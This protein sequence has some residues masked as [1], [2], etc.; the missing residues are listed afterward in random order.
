VTGAE[1]FRLSLPIFSRDW[2]L[3]MV[4]PA[5]PSDPAVLHLLESYEWP[6]NIRELKNA[7]EHA[8]VFA[9]DSLLL[10]ENF[11]RFSAFPRSRTVRQARCGRLRTLSTTRSWRHSKPRI[12]KIG[13][14]AE[15]LG[16]TRK[17]LLDKRKKYGLI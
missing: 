15:I 8:L 16:I 9:K 12:N 13:R 1:T 17:T 4:I 10:T 5:R 6:G 14:A 2:D 11:P 7:I 3:C